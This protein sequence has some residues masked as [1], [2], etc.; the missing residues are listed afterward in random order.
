MPSATTQL[1]SF[2]AQLGRRGTTMLAVLALHVVLAI[3]LIAGMT[4]RPPLDIPDVVPKIVYVPHVEP[5]PVARLDPGTPDI[6]RTMPRIIDGPLPLKVV[7]EADPFTPP[8]AVVPTGGDSVAPAPVSRVQVLRGDKP[9]YPAALRR[10]GKE[11]SVGVRVRVGAT[12]RAELVEIAD[13]SGFPAFDSAALEAVK[14]WIFAPAQ[15]ATG[16][17]ASWVAFKVS[18]RLT[19]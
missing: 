19:D 6:G 7:P 4:L 13:P 1:Y 12:G 5:V 17:I 15:T 3:G 8:V 9:Y 18:F 11:G 10:L 2:P 16:P 14:R